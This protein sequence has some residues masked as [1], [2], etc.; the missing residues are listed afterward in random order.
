MRLNDLSIFSSSANKFIAASL[1]SFVMMGKL[2]LECLSVFF[3]RHDDTMSDYAIRLLPTL[4]WQTGQTTSVILTNHCMSTSP[5]S[6][7]V[8]QVVREASGVSI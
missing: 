6:P 4:G 5:L 1:T 3:V 2:T 7:Q 8:L